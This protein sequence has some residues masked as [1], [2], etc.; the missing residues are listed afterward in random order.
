[1]KRRGESM[2]K[3]EELSKS[4]NDEPVI[5]GLNLLVHDESLFFYKGIQAPEKVHF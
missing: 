3:I 4:C 2:I 1:M 5:K